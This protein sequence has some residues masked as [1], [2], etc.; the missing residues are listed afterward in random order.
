MPKRI[1]AAS[2]VFLWAALVSSGASAAAPVYF[3]TGIKIGEVTQDSAIVWVRLTAAP[4][5]NRDG[6]V[7]NPHKSPTR[8]LVDVPDIPVSLWEGSAE[9][10]SGE[11]R[12]GVSID[13]ALRTAQWTEWTAVGPA[14][15]YSHKFPL[16]A[17]QPDTQYYVR[18]E[19]RSA[20]DAPATQAPMG[21]FRTA[22]SGDTWQ[23]VWFTVITGQMYYHR[24]DVNGFKIYPAMAKIR[25]SYPDFIVPTGDFT[26]YDRDN[27]RGKTVDLAR[28]HW[29]RICSLPLV[30]DFYYKVPGYWEKD[31]HDTFFD[32][33]WPTYEAPWI[34]PLT[35]AE[36]AAVFEEQTPVLKPPFRTVR[37]G[38]GLQVWF[39]E[40]RDYRSPNEDPDGPEKTIWGNEQKE[41]LKNTILESDAVFKVLVS[42]TAI[43]G[44]DNPNQTDSHADDAFATEGKEFRLWT[45][46]NR[47]DHFYVCCGDRHWQ[48]MST[49]PESGLREF[50]CGPTTDMHALHGPQ[51]E[52]KWH[53]FY[54]E[55]GGFLSVSISTGEIKVLARP[56]RV[57]QE[58]TVPT[59]IFRFHDVDGKLLYEYRDTS[60][61]DE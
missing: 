60:L 1:S 4:E 8:V 50:A 25:E 5:A 11:I 56:Q 26:Y 28:L 47:L 59:I 27:P 3:A 12:V 10:I 39:P 20:A 35:Y 29:Q 48:Y 16:A 2:L 14:T 23:N 49:D 6:V 38:E 45:R 54:R 30:R 43:V 32:D 13:P 42:P 40:G 33:C 15:D 55:G 31:D 34:E 7:P 19:G 36:G 18:A 9:G 44:P 22:G 57:V 58:K 51:Y 46:D 37:W 17:L 21:Q 24:D 52:P 41:W 53:S 61:V